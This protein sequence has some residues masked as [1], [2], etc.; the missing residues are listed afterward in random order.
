MS[1]SGGGNMGS[2]YYPSAPSFRGFRRGSSR[3]GRG[4]YQGTAS[5][6]RRQRD[7]WALIGTFY[8]IMILFLKIDSCEYDVIIRCLLSHLHCMHGN[9]AHAV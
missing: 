4:G 8:I 2:F 7:R 3:G 9:S 5:R 6:G 1:P